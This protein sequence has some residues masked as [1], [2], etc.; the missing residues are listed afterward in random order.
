MGVGKS[1]TANAVADRLGLD[2]RAS[3]LDIERL[4]GQTGGQIAATQDLTI[5][6]R[7]ESAVLLGALADPRRMVI[8]AA[9]SVIDDPIS[10]DALR[11][12]ASVIVLEAP[13][14]T[15]LARQAQGAHRRPMDHDQLAQLIE[16]RGSAVREVAA[17]VLDAT[18][19]VD[20]LADLIVTEF[21]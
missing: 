3:D 11:R 2:H 4:T 18:S 8:S 7:I 5:L 20:Q 9:A 17:L 15:L 1:T 12:R 14:D 6:H 21:R 16:R 19:P 10:V 13:I